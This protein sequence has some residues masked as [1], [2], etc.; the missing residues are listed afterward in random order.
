MPKPSP[1]TARTR[2]R[3]RLG[4]VVKLGRQQLGLTQLELSRRT[5]LSKSYVSYL[6]AGQYEEIGVAK[7]AL[8]VEVLGVSADQFL[9][10]AGY[11]DRPVPDRPEPRQYLATQFQLEPDQVQAGL[12][13]LA[14]LQTRKKARTKTAR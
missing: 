3:Q 12:D 8:L 10:Q 11:L 14:F 5:G 6:E 9:T 13:Y 2:N 1:A 7:F 4:E